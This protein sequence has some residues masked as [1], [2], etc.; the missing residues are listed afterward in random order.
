MGVLRCRER[1]SRR[2][3]VRILFGDAKN[4]RRFEN[5]CESALCSTLKWCVGCML[6]TM[7]DT[8]SSVSLRAE[9]FLAVQGAVLFLSRRVGPFSRTCESGRSAAFRRASFRR[10]DG[11]GAGLAFGRLSPRPSRGSP[12]STSPSSMPSASP[13]KL[14]ITRCRIAGMTHVLDVLEADVEAAV[15]QAAHLGGEHDR[16]RA[17]GAGAARGGTGWSSGS[18]TRPAGASPACSGS[19]SPA[20]AGRRSPRGPAAVLAGSRRRP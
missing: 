16:L 3:A 10:G 9:Q 12:S 11:G 15:E 7:C 1:P 19:R 6:R 8:S 17:A 14:R 20:R 5:W 18:R 2:I 13:S 4:R